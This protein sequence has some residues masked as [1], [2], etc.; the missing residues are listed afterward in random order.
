[1]SIVYVC[2]PYSGNVS[3]N[4]QKAKRAMLF[5]LKQG[6]APFAPHLLYPQILDDSLPSERELGMNAGMEVLGAADMMYVFGDVISV[7]MQLEIDEAKFMKV[8]IIR[9]PWELVETFLEANET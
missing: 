1:M 6:H 3:E 7:G 2:S 8:P 5:C 4:V 9:I